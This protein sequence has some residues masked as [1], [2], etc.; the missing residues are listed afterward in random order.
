MLAFTVDSGISL[1]KVPPPAK[2]VVMP[3]G[4]LVLLPTF[5]LLVL[6]GLVTDP[7]PL[8]VPI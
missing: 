4:P 2:P 3:E 6:I 5:L 1:L 7:V 8:V